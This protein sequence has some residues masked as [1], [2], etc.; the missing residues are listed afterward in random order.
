MESEKTTKNQTNGVQASKAEPPNESDLKFLFETNEV[1]E[2]NSER[3]GVTRY[4]IDKKTGYA[5]MRSFDF[6]FHYSSSSPSMDCY[7]Y[8]ISY[9][10]LLEAT[11]GRSPLLHQ[12]LRGIN[13]TNWKEYLDKLQL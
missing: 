5:Y 7:E 12:K 8:K 1:S 3:I 9:E 11:A 4:Y 6:N 13:E 10:R 2:D